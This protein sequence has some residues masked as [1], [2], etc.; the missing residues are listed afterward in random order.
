MEQVDYEAEL[1]K[2]RLSHPFS[3]IDMS[4]REFSLITGL[5]MKNTM[6][7]ADPAR[8]LELL[9]EIKTNEQQSAS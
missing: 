6:G 8:V 4:E 9:K 3:F 1:A 5:I 7:K 2:I